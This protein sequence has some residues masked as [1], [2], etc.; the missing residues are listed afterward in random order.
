MRFVRGCVVS[1][2]VYFALGAA[3]LAI[4]FDGRPWGWIVFAIA[5]AVFVTSSSGEVERWRSGADVS[6]RAPRDRAERKR[7]DAIRHEIGSDAVS[8]LSAIGSQKRGDVGP[9]ARSNMVLLELYRQHA[10][11]GAADW[12][13]VI[14][15]VRRLGECLNAARHID[16]ERLPYDMLDDARY[17][18]QRLAQS[19]RTA[20]HSEIG[21][22]IENSAAGW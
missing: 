15:T 17:N 14:A 4:G 21:N 12:Q 9:A 6:I 10:A 5:L 8:W 13:R 1:V 22:E 11:Q 18:A 20:G 2:F 7:L 19:A 3:A 16:A